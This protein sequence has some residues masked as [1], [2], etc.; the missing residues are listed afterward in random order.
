MMFTFNSCRFVVCFLSLALS[1]N[2]DTIRG[3]LQRKLTYPTN[4]VLLSS[5]GSNGSLGSP[6]PPDTDT[7]TA[8]GIVGLTGNLYL[9]ASAAAHTDPDSAWTFTFPA[10]FTTAAVSET[11]FVR[12]LGTESNP[13]V[14]YRADDEDDANYQEFAAKVTWL[15]SGP[16]TLGAS[17][18]V[19]GTMKS[20]ATITLGATARSGDLCAD[21][22][23]VLGAAAIS[24]SIT[25]LAAI[26]VGAGSTCGAIDAGAA[27]TVGAGSFIASLTAGGA[28]TIGATVVCEIDNRPWTTCTNVILPA[29]VCPDLS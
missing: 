1:V 16:I 9:D 4:N 6:I 17:S 20:G 11:V 18:F 14:L 28:T 24:R 19:G 23:I 8:I 25:G 7:Y 2:A 15:V 29:F 21:A 22:A 27:I 5:L 13:P 10:A 12:L 26:T 3:A